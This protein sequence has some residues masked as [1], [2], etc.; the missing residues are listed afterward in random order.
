MPMAAKLAQLVN[1]LV[2]GV[3]DSFMMML[4]L[5][6]SFHSLIGMPHH[7]SFGKLLSCGSLPLVW[8]K[9]RYL[10][11]RAFVCLLVKYVLALYFHWY[12]PLSSWSPSH[13]MRTSH[14][15]SPRW[16]VSAGNTC[17]SFWG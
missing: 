2:V 4:L 17:H 5:S 16:R 10:S 8:A 11:R 9:F 12:L 1:C 14:A 15:W 6:L 13:S 7:L 3:V